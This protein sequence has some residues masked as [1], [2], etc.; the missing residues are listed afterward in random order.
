MR[1]RR[2][3]IPTS[4]RNRTTVVQPQPSDYADRAIPASQVSYNLSCLNADGRYFQHA[5]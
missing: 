5:F 4:G 3:N 1:W 2:E